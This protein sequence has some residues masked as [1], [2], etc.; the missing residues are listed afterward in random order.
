MPAP[1]HIA[2]K[3]PRRWRLQACPNIEDRY[4]NQKQQALKA[5]SKPQEVWE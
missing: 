3:N 4:N 5:T 2:E 1:R